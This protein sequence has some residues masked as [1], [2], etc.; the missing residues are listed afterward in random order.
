M[1]NQ[2]NRAELA[3]SLLQ[4]LTSREII[5]LFS[6]GQ[7]NSY[8]AILIQL[9]QPQNPLIDEQMTQNEKDEMLLNLLDSQLNGLIELEILVAHL[10]RTNE[11]LTSTLDGLLLI[12]ADLKNDLE[13]VLDRVKDA[14]DGAIAILDQNIELYEKNRAMERLTAQIR[15][16]IAGMERKAAIQPFVVAGHGLGFATG[17]TVFG[18]GIANNNVQLALTGGGI[19]I[20]TGVIYISG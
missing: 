17:G 20:A 12:I 11:S 5:S 14:E 10:R 19:V 4:Q 8:K 2:S 13:I 1:A 9:S 15:R 7:L 16:D 18:M 3:S 6:E